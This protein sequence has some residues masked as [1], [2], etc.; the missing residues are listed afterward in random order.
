MSEVEAALPLMPVTQGPDVAGGAVSLEPL[1]LCTCPDHLC[2][3]VSGTRLGG[4]AGKHLQGS[5]VSFKS[6]EK[7]LGPCV[8]VEGGRGLSMESGM[9]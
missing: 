2:S 6:R 1:W 5:L 9:K 8:C 3:Q 7:D 4:G